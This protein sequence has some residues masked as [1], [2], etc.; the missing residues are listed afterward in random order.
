VPLPA[1][2]DGAGFR[3]AVTQ[4]FA[5]ALEKFKPQMLFVSAGFDAHINDPLA[6]LALVEDDYVWVTEFIKDVAHRYSHDRIVSS[7]EGGYN[8][9]ALASSATA[10]IRTLA[11]L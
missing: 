9:S 6:Q 8:L 1:Y 7:L 4:Q 5:P 11:G 10:H 3:K 2:T